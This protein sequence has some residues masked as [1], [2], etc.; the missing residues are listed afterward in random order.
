MF[1]SSWSEHSVAQEALQSY[2]AAA[3]EEK[4]N[5]D[6]INQFV[7]AQSFV[8]TCSFHPQSANKLCELVDET[9]PIA[10]SHCCFFT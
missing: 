1:N 6:L 4:V 5:S 7:K 3:K 10:S 9:V 2:G 8:K